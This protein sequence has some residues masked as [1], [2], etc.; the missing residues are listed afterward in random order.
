M[1]NVLVSETGIGEDGHDDDHDVA[2]ATCRHC[3][4]MLMFRVMNMHVR[5]SVWI[6]DSDVRPSTVKMASLTHEIERLLPKI[7]LALF[8]SVDEGLC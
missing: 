2:V 5:C 1:Q 6:V 4:C 3:K 8:R 7:K